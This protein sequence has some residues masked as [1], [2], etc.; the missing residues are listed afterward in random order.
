MCPVYRV[1]KLLT[2]SNPVMSYGYEKVRFQAFPVSM[3]EPR[4]YCRREN[5]AVVFVEANIRPEKDLT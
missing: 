5:T 3:W 4:V 2:E 1:P